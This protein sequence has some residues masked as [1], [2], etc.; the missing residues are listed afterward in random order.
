MKK[1][2]LVFVAAGILGLVA[3]VLWLVPILPHT[4]QN[5]MPNPGPGP[6]IVTPPVPGPQTAGDILKLT[7]ALSDPYVLAGS[8][9]E[10]FLKADIEAITVGGTDRAPVNLA[11]VLDRSGSMAGEKIAQCRRAARQLVQ[12]LD[13]RDRF[14]LITFGSDVTT[15][16]SSTLA[17]PGAK[18]RMLAAIDGIAE[19]GGTNLSGA[20][21]AALA[22][23]VP[24]RNQYNVSRV[25]LLSDGQANEGIADPAGLSGLARRLASQGL[26]I[27]SIGVGLDFNEVV[28]ESLAEYGGGSYHFLNDT[29]QLAGIFA[30]ELKQAVATVATSTSLAVIPSPGVTVA[31]VYSYITEA[32]GSTTSVR[33]PDFVSGQHRRVVVRLLVPASTPGQVEVAR[34]ALAYADVT[35]NRAPGSVQVAVS[36][37]VTNDSTLALSNRNKDVAAVAAHASALQSMRNASAF[38]QEGKRDEAEQQV[39]AAQVVLQKAEVDYGKNAEFDEDLGEAK[40]LEGALAAPAGSDAV[41]LGAKRAH[42]FSNAKR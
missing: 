12:S 21:E 40:N 9:R 27:S 18:E 26:T 31:E 6:N 30:G 38:A 8:A 10:V 34:V 35:H 4:G 42:A 2:A 17:T 41:N 36:A 19:L 13:S 5:P 39:R 32:Q 11:L 37:S 14:A 22:E 23:V 1:T 33:L 28:M 24:F 25:V 20:L 7:A 15:L 16:V 29:E 3:L